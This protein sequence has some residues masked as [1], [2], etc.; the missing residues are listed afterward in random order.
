MHRGPIVNREQR[1][2]ALA[3]LRDRHPALE[4]L[5]ERH[6]LPPLRPRV[7]SAL[8]FGAL[9]RSILYQQLAGKA[10]AAIHG[11]FVEALGGRVTT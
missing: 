2:V 11:R 5:I 6:G 7:P 10:A 1:L 4:A 3:D 9:A 8:R